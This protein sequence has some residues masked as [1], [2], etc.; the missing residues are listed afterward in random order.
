MCIEPKSEKD[1]KVL[2]ACLFFVTTAII[3]TGYFHEQPDEG[4]GYACR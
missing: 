4:H 3:V 2:L 1:E